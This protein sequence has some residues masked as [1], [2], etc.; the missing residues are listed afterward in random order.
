MKTARFLVFLSL[1][2]VG[3]S[4]AYSQTVD[5]VRQ[6]GTGSVDVSYGVSAD[7]LGNV[8]I[9]GYTEGSLEGTI[10]GITDGFLSKYNSSGTLLWTEQFGSSGYDRSYGVSADGLG[11]V[12]ISGNTTGSLEGTNA[13]RS[14]VFVSKYNDSGSLLWTKQLGSSSHETSFG[15]S[16]DDLGNVFISGSTSGNL[17]GTNGVVSDAFVS[18]YNT[19]GTL[20]WTT[21][22]DSGGHD[23]SRSVSADGLGNVFISGYTDSTLGETS[24]GSLD[25]FVSKFDTSGALLWT[26]QLGTSVFDISYGVS[27]DGL[28][29]VF[30]SGYTDSILDGTSGGGRDAFVSKYDDDGTLLWT[31]QTGASSSDSSYGVSADEMGNVYISGYT[32]GSLDGA[33]V[34]GADAFVSKYDANGRLLWTKQSGT[35]SKDESNS[36]SADGLGNV[37]ISGMTEGSFGGTHAGDLD[38]FVLKISCVAGDFD[39]DCDVDGQ[40]FLTWQ[41]DGGSGTELSAWQSYYGES[42]NAT[43]QSSLAEVPEPTSLLLLTVAAWCNSARFA[44]GSRGR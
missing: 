42:I 15:V 35:S 33:N 13:G 22:I 5:W 39:G 7:G 9:S 21:Q 3:F 8:Y 29:N 4:N 41:R 10:A 43:L 34:G 32:F 23:N 6:L 19:S 28:G 36:V 37:Y 40:D 16:A 14:D 31:R 24:A 17:G 25:G 11:S 12:Y 26:E 1:F 20:L 2:F 27:A 38:A 44:F 18:K 30:I